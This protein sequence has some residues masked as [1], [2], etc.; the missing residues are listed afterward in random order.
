[1][2]PILAYLWFVLVSMGEPYSSFFISDLNRYLP[3]V[4]FLNEELYSSDFG[5]MDFGGG[6]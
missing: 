4:A 6:L 2:P 5:G 3:R 1:M